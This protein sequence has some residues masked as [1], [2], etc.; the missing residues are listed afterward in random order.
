MDDDL[1][2]ND[3]YRT[4]VKD[5]IFSKPLTAPK[6]LMIEVQGAMHF[7]LAQNPEWYGSANNKFNVELF[8]GHFA[9]KD[10]KSCA[11][12]LK[13]TVQPTAAAATDY[14]LSLKDKFTVSESCGLSGLDA[15]NEIH[16]YP[17]VEI[18]ISA[19]Q[20]N[21]QVANAASKYQTQFKLTGPIYFQ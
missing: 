20:A 19:V 3:G 13:S 2:S 5:T 6:G 11:V 9:Q 1:V 15:W 8:L 17:L 7:N 12:T 14:S 16:S 18:K 21:A 10:G 4:G